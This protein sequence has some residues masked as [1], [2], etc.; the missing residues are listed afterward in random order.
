MNYFYDFRFIFI[1]EIQNRFS[2]IINK[3]NFPKFSL[4]LKKYYDKKIH[5]FKDFF[6]QKIS[7]QNLFCNRTLKPKHQPSPD[8]TN[9]E[10][11]M[12][13]SHIC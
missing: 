9:N 3:P 10:S 2:K 5:N 1:Q 13:R 6:E 4:H 12:H 7:H 11:M 8:I